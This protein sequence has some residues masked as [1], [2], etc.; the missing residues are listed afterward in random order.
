[1]NEKITTH[2]EYVARRDE[3]LELARKIEEA[4]N[5]AYSGDNDD[6]HGN[7]RFIANLLGVDPMVV[8]SVYFMKHITAI[9][10]FAK[11]PDIKQAEV[12]DERFA[13]ALNY[14]KFG[15]SLYKEKEIETNE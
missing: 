10:T 12:L 9:L 5:P 15:Y 4:K 13:D 2:T 3:L 11:N 1:M 8:W 14:L 7:F 6:Y